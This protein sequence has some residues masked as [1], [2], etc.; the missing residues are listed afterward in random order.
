MICSMT[1][2]PAP[3]PDLQAYRRAL[4]LQQVEALSRLAEIGMQLAE[5]AGARA[6]AAQ[7]AAAQA[8]SGGHPAE[9]AAPRV[10]DPRA[11]DPTVQAREAGTAFARYALLVQRSLAQRM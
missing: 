10:E 7:V 6:L 4:G 1:D 9:D 8:D 5:G 2:T 3:D 11:E